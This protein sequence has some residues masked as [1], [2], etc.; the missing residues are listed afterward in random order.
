MMRVLPNMAVMVA[1]DEA[2]TEFI[3]ETAIEMDQPMY[4]RLSR[5][6]IP[7]CHLQEVKYQFGKGAVVH[8]GTDITIIAC[9]L[10]VSQAVEAAKVLAGKGIHARVIDMFCVKPID[11]DIIVKAA[12]E[13]GA[14]VTAEEHTIIGGLGS[15]VA[16][17]LA[18]EDCIVP[19][20]MIGMR[21]CHGE[22]GDYSELLKKYGMDVDSI[23]AAAEKSIL[24]K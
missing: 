8:D 19:T 3:I 2:T 24:K 5:D 17:V 20:E 14:F 10:M 13:T 4:I 18:Q 15:A 1:S 12:K 6:G 16:E 9:G 22:S 21:D 7:D 23:V 11:R